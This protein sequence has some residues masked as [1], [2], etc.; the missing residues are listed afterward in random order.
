MVEATG[1]WGLGAGG[2]LE[3]PGNDQGRLRDGTG[4]G[5]TAHPPCVH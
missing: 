2:T 4:T 3:A 5:G 1:T